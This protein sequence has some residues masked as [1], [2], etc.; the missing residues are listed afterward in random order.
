MRLLESNSYLSLNRGTACYGAEVHHPAL[1][2]ELAIH[3]T[4]DEER[5]GSHERIRER[6]IDF[7]HQRPNLSGRVH[8]NL[9]LTVLSWTQLLTPHKRR[10]DSTR[11]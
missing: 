11:R 9:D 8:A 5:Y 1:Q 4:H 7:S 6:H 2:G 10:V 3:L